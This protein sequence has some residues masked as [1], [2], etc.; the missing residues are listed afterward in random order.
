MGV[1]GP[2]AALAGVVGVCC[3]LPLLLSLGV[4]GAFAGAS[5]QS[6]A[7]LALGLTSAVADP[8]NRGGTS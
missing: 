4:L 3:G 6:W 7:L 8:A 1:I 5:L 2:V